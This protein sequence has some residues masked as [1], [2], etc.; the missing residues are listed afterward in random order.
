LTF[1]DTLAECRSRC[2]NLVSCGLALRHVALFSLLGLR[3]GIGRRLVELFA[4]RDRGL[5]IV[6][7]IA[8]IEGALEVLATL[9]VFLFTMI[10]TQSQNAVEESTHERG[11]AAGKAVMNEV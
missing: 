7:F 4:G 5:G 10:G 3:V 11:F 9:I 8:E 1:F 2:K 6:G